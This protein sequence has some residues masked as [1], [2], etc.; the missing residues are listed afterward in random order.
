MVSRAAARLSAGNLGGANVQVRD[1]VDVCTHVGL[2]AGSK[3][4]LAELSIQ[5]KIRRRGELIREELSYLLY[6]PDALCRY[7]RF[8]A[9]HK[10]EPLRARNFL[11]EH[12]LCRP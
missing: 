3:S 7:V 2:C 9:L 8:F 1:D 6:F 10:D 12:G 11:K 4:D 5:S